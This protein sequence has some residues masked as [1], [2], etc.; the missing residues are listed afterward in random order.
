MQIPPITTPQYI[1]REYASPRAFHRDA[2]EL[3]AR[4]H[5]TVSYTVGLAHQRIVLR[6]LQAFGL[7]PHPVVITYQSPTNP[8]PVVSATS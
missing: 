2:R 3:Y 7:R 1:M 5:Y 4:T 6:A 8:W